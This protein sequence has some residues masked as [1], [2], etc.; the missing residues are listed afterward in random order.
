MTMKVT[1]RE[2]DGVT[3]LD[4][5]GRLTLGSGTAVL[6]ETLKDLIQ[7]G[8]KNIVL[9]LGDVTYMD[10]TGL[11][12]LVSAYASARKQSGDIKLLNLTKRTH[13]LLEITKLYTV[14]DVYED[15]ERAISAFRPEEVTTP[16][17]S[18]V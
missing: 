13:D 8:H 2:V 11:G 14:F 16:S 3:I 18:G 9:N 15:E 5:S 1:Q 17:G 12:E 4:L 7:N 6:H 10:S